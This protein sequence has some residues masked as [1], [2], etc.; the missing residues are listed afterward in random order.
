MESLGISPSRYDLWKP[1]PSTEDLPTTGPFFVSSYSKGEFIELSRNPYYVQSETT[2]TG[3]T[4][5]TDTNTSGPSITNSQT[6]PGYGDI[7]TQYGLYIGIGAVVVVAVV[8]LVIRRAGDPK[9]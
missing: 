8:L 9:R 6:A 4:S 3:S 1:D 5:T 7:L 2:T